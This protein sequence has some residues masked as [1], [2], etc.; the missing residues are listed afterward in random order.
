MKKILIFDLDGTLAPSKSPLDKEMSTLLGNLLQKKNVAIISG[1]GF[2]QFEK[3]VLNN[4]LCPE[5][6]LEKLV[7]FPTKGGTMYEFK[8]GVWNEIYAKSFSEEDKSKIIKAVDTI[9]HE[10]D[11][12]SDRC[13]GK[14]LDDRGSEFTF[15]AL[16]QEAPQAEKEKWDRNF[17]KRKILEER[18][19][20]LLPE[21]DVAIGGSTS[22]DITLKGINKAFAINQIFTRFAYKKD[23][24]LF[25]GDA[26]FSGGNDASVKTTGVETF[27]V[28]SVDETKNFIRNIINNNE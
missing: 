13:F 14:R 15:S 19:K 17:T 25:V 1:G 26:L 20:K 4:L 18:F 6:L 9:S 23:E 22:I 5:K 7:I 11:F 2:P 8:K 27:A 24:I 10:V 3:Q 28:K 12:L 21:F 16:G